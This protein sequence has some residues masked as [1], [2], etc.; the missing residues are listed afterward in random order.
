MP[1]LRARAQNRSVVGPGT[2]SASARARRAVAGSLR[3]EPGEGQLGESDEVRPGRGGLEERGLAP[4]PV[5]G[6]VV[7]RV[8]LDERDPQARQAFSMSAT[9]F[10]MAGPRTLR[11]FS[12]TRTSSSIRAPPKSR[13]FSTAS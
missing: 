6:R 13:N 2:V 11:P 1:V 12:V 4:G 7:R 10:G 9:V 8:L 3:V 5:G